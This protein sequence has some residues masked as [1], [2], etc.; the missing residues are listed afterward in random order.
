MGYPI[1]VLE[2]PDNSGKSTLA[3]SL[4][5]KV[6]GKIMHA[7]YRFKGRMFEYHLATFRLALKAAQHQPVI[8]DRWW[9]S[10]SAYG[11]TYREGAEYSKEQFAVLQQLA[12]DYFVSYTYCVPTRF[13]EYWYFATYVW[14]SHEEM[15]EKD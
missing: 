8:L 7:T 5:K 9:P 13:E 10:E 6:G 2:G 14:K 15:F 12:K 3:K 11:N 1:F 4:S